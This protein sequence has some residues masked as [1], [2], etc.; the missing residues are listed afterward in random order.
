MCSGGRSLVERAP[1]VAPGRPGCDRR[2]CWLDFA[3]R[4]D[5][6]LIGEGGRNVAITRFD[7]R[8]SDF[9][10]SLTIEAAD[11]LTLNDDQQRAI[12]T[13]RSSNAIAAASCR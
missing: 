10:E 2:R 1:A 7:V 8:A 6:R 3:M 12:A 4:F 13:L 11:D 9:D 5:R